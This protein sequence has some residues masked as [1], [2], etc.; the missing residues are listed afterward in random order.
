MLPVYLESCAVALGL[1]AR[2][3]VSITAPAPGADR[4]GTAA[5]AAP[6]A[7]GF[8]RVTVGAAANPATRP[9]DGGPAGLALAVGPAPVAAGCWRAVSPDRPGLAGGPMSGAAGGGLGRLLAE[10]LAEPAG[11]LAARIRAIEAC[12]PPGPAGGERSRGGQSRSGPGLSGHGPGGPG[13]SGHG[14]GGH[15]LGGHGLGGHGLGGR[16]VLDDAVL[17]DWVVL[18]AGPARLACTVVQITGVA[19]PVAVALITGLAALGPVPVTGDRAAGPAPQP[20]VS[21]EEAEAHT[22]GGPALAASPDP[23]EAGSGEPASAEAGGLPWVW[24]WAGPA[25]G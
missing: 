15:G 22:A 9:A 20:S 12:L 11:P 16:L 6:D 19:T 13:L 7:D 3:R 17:D 5:P 8:S 23:A 14:L 2:L 25:G 4:G 24:L 18:R 21:H 10:R 1:D